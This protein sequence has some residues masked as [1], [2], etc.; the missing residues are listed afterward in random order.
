VVL[1]GRGDLGDLGS[2]EDEQTTDQRIIE[3]FL[4]EAGQAARTHA[5]KFVGSSLRREEKESS[6][7]LPED[8]QN[9][10]MALWDWYWQR[11]GKDDAAANP[12][13]GLFGWWFVSGAFPMEWSVNRLEEFVSVVPKPEP[14]TFIVERLAEVAKAG[15]AYPRAAVRILKCMVEG[16]DENWHIHS[17][18]EEAMAVLRSAMQAV[19]EARKEAESLIDHLGRR[20]FVEFGQ[21]LRK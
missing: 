12:Q 1:Y 8:I 19:G 20:G 14:D 2:E 13:S 9:R 6:E 18:Q 7:D 16:D 3:R 11:T 15:Q 17:W 4:T 5:V 10:F 21:L